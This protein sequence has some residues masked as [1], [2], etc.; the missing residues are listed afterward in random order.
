MRRN[1]LRI[2]A[3]LTA[4]ASVVLISA[5]ADVRPAPQPDAVSSHVIVISIDGLRADAIEKYNARTLLRL[6]RDG[7]FAVGA[8]TITPSRT[9]PAHVSMLTGVTPDI[10]GITWNSD[11]TEKFGYVPVPTVFELAKDHGYTTAAFFSKTKFHHL[12]KPGTLDYSQAPDG[13]NWMA[14]KTVADVQQYLKFRRPNLLFVH[15]GEPDYAGHGFGWMSFA[16]GWAV[17]R[18]DG[19]VEVLLK[20][21]ERAFGVGNFTILITADHGG[22]NR[23]HGGTDPRDMTIP[24]I[25]WGKGV[26]S[27]TVP[28]DVKTTDTAATVLWLLGVSQPEH[29]SGKAVAAALAPSALAEAM[30]R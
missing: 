4:L 15:I 22:H 27:G 17:R 21:A 16:Y 23:S 3:T 20:A 11:E 10:H 9:L 6:A 24:W 12:Q 1:P 8:Q 26:A 19:A 25:A 7:A 28:T 29:W 18:A 2:G 5:G 14:T 13:S 30:M